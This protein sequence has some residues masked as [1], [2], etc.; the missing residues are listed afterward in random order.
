MESFS[1]L[2]SKN[3]GK[4]AS[5]VGWSKK[6][7]SLNE[8]SVRMLLTFIALSYK[9]QCGFLEPKSY[10]YH[11]AKW[12]ISYSCLYPIFRP[13]WVRPFR[14]NCGPHPPFFHELFGRGNLLIHLIV[15]L[16]VNRGHHWPRI[17][18]ASILVG[19]LKSILICSLLTSTTQCSFQLNSKSIEIRREKLTPKNTLLI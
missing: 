4:P 17:A 3:L 5:I 12:N 6:Q 2:V 13:S 7:R 18:A 16:L 1:L 8:S 14:W 15:G 11:H 9:F 19:H 10:S